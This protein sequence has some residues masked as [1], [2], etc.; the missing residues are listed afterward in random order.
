MLGI[1]WKVK[2]TGSAIRKS[3]GLALRVLD[4]AKM[5]PAWSRCIKQ[6]G[7]AVDKEAFMYVADI[8][9]KAIKSDLQIAIVGNVK[10]DK[11]KLDAI[12][13]VVSKKHNP[14]S[15]SG[16]KT[17][18]KDHTPCDHSG[19]AE[20]KAAGWSSAVLSD[21]VRSKVRGLEPMLCDKHILMP[22][23]PAQW[24]TIAKKLKKGVKDFAKAKYE[25]VGDQ[26]PAVF[27]YLTLSSGTLCASDVKS[28]INSKLSAS[29]IESAINKHL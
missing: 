25:K 20:V 3:I 27:G 4:P 1:N 12:L 15:I 2:G 13:E 10:L 7:H 17:K 24:E 11:A 18:P 22:L 29:S 21:Y 23:K 14:S 28:A 6:L 8:A 19:F 5:F 26:L 16:T 9:A